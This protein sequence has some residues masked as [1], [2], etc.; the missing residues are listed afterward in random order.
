MIP[1]NKP[2]INLACPACGGKLQNTPS[3]NRVVCDHCGNE[4]L[5]NTAGVINRID[6]VQEVSSPETESAER[7]KKTGDREEETEESKEERK[8]E[9]SWMM[10]I[11]IVL[12]GAT[13]LLEQAGILHLTNWWAIFLVVPAVS[14]FINVFRRFRQEG[15][16]THKVTAPIISG[17]A[18]LVLAFFFLFDLDIGKLWPVFV[19]LAGI[20]ILLSYLFRN[21]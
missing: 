18:S 13:F 7:G 19:I 15:R 10:G 6:P 3:S 8:R 2:F 11:S 9:N 14:S 12:V 21:K 1:E 4:Y 17:L 20:S 5:V 16:V